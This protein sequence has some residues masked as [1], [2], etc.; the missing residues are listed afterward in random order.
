MKKKAEN[1]KTPPK[2]SL[3]IAGVIGVL[4]TDE[5]IQEEAYRIRRLN[6]DEKA[7]EKGMCECIMFD[8]MK[9]ESGFIDGA[10]WIRKLCIAE[11]WKAVEQWPDFNTPLT[12]S[13]VL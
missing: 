7:K 6:Q 1:L 11:A 2:P 8:A 5:A 3:D 9:I 10:K 12:K 13:I 4:P